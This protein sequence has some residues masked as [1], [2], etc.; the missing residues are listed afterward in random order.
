MDHCKDKNEAPV[1]GLL[2][3]V[4]WLMKEYLAK[5]K[6]NKFSVSIS[7]FYDLFKLNAL[8]MSLLHCFIL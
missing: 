3:P 6:Y 4:W 1:M 8:N 2:K 7:D 5:N